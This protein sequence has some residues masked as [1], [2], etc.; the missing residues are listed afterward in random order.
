MAGEVWKERVNCDPELGR[1]LRSS[2]ELVGAVVR[3]DGR[4]VASRALGAV[5]ESI[6][7]EY[8]VNEC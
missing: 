8:Q 1:R 3:I 5:R 2:A 4:T 6:V 7:T